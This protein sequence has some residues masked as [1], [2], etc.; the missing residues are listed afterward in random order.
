M[1]DFAES[2]RESVPT[3]MRALAQAG[4]SGVLRV[5]GR[6]AEAEVMFFHGDV[7]WARS[8]S[9][10]C[11]GEAL[12]ERG[13]ISASDLQGVLAMQKRKKQRQ[14]IATILLGLG[15]VNR[16]V[17]ETEIEIQVLDVL[18][19][20]FDWGSGEYGFEAARMTRDEL[21]GIVLPACGK[22]DSLLQGAGIPL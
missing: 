22:V 19:M 8:S 15:L 16:E 14:P 4:N 13:A 2:L 18:R 7:V 5:R 12:T 6:D 21:A 3:V 1:A 9:A 10:R 20:I 11:L 17:A